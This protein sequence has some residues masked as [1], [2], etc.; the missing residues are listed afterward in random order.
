MDFRILGPLEVL[1]EDRRVPLGGVKLRAL[2]ALLVMHANQTLSSERLIDDLWGEHPPANATKAIQV[3]ISRLRR[4]LEASAGK[5]SGG[6]VV[7]RDT[8]YELR[9]GPETVDCSAIPVSLLTML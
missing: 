9:T 7:T 2:L 3:Q 8:G 6:V 5:G 4:A 1:D